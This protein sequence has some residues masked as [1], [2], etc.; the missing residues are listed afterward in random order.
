MGIVPSG[1]LAHTGADRGHL[2]NRRELQEREDIGRASACNAAVR[3]AASALRGAWARAGLARG[4]ARLAH[5][6]L[7]GEETVGAA[8]EALAVERV[9]MGA[10][11]LAFCALVCTRADA[12]VATGG[13]AG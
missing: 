5:T 10:D 11:R 8:R 9:C 6:I 2:L 13:V 7:V 4:R 12:R 1:A 3:H